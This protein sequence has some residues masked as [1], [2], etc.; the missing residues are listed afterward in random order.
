MSSL[1]IIGNGF[2][3]AHGIPTKYSDFRSFLIDLFPD[4]LKF[5][6]EIIYLED[7]ERIDVSEFAAEILLHAMDS[8]SGEN[9]CNFEEA[10]AYINFNNKLPRPNHKEDETDE[11]D[12]E[13]MMHY[14]LYT[15]MLTSAFINCSKLWE[16]YFRLW[17]KNVQ[18]QIDVGAYVPKE[19]LIELFSQP[20]TKF[21]SFNYTKTLQI[22]YGVKKVIHVHN[23]VGQ[24]LIFGHG[25]D[26][27]MY[28]Q[29]N[30]DPMGLYFTSSFLDD[31]IMS[32]KKDTGS[33]LKKYHEFFNKLDHGI[34]YIRTVS[35]MEKL[36][37]STSRK[38]LKKFHSTQ[39]GI[40]LHMKL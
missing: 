4:A 21:F 32:F 7:A 35:A 34:K 8:A 17:I 31:M 37:V 40:S 6:D 19:S 11:E 5:R 3:I 16:D 15:D 10:L 23:R 36:T 13:L 27:I 26:N 30:N 20:D 14:L 1:F 9:W 2:D 25:E 24:K 38:L 12:H 29:F 33:Q 39:H 18:Q 28:D 22:L